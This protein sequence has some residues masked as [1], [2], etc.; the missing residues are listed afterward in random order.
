[1]FEI[2]FGIPE[3]KEQWDSL[4]R[5]NKDG[6]ITRDELDLLKKWAK[7]IAFL[8]TNPRHPSL[9]THEITTLSAKFGHRVWQSYLENRKPK[10][11]RL[12]LGLRAGTKTNNPHWPGTTPRKICNFLP[13]CNPI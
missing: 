3:I 6:S 11:Y 9:Q 8:A 10:P 4:N 1:M 5:K 7:A 2:L 13:C 12:F